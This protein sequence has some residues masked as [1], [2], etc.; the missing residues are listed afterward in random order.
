[1]LLIS[2]LEQMDQGEGLGNQFFVRPE[3]WASFQE[4]WQLL[5]T[6]AHS[7]TFFLPFFH[8]RGDGFWTVFD[9]NG[10][11]IKKVFSSFRQME[12]QQVFGMFSEE[13]FV[14][15]ISPEN[16]AIILGFLLEKYFPEN[17]QAYLGK[18]QI[19]DQLLSLHKSL[20]KEDVPA[21][22]KEATDE[23]NFVRKGVFKKIIPRVY[24]FTCSISGMRV[25]SSFHTQMID[26][27]HIVPFSRSHDDS[28]S[29]GIAL[30]P[31]LHRAFDRGLISIDD[32]Y[33]VL[34]SDSFVETESHPYALSNFKQKAIVL[35]FGKKYYPDPEKLAWHR[36]HI[37]K[38]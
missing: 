33:R 5:V 6:T 34:V 2:L 9:G 1:M 35:P 19:P 20:L 13:F 27:C 37:F 25:D 31:N 10:K 18:S 15:F 4:N 16:R 32:Q 36:E 28:I 3:L 29:N 22:K 17:Q 7:P 14:Q 26:A 38:R 23:E 8:L 11:E 12:A 24:N 30:C 21:Y